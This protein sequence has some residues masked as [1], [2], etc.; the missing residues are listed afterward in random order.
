MPFATE[1]AQSTG[2]FL[3]ER[4]YMVFVYQSLHQI[5]TKIL[6]IV[7]LKREAKIFFYI[8]HFNNTNIIWAVSI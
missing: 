6:H 8:K 7:E 4:S 5:E 3:R 2:F 1:S